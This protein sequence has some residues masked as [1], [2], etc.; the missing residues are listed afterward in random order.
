MSLLLLC[1]CTFILVAEV[2]TTS[3][4]GRISI[5][6]VS[7]GFLILIDLSF[8]VC[9]S[10]PC[11]FLA[12]SLSCP[13]SWAIQKDY[14]FVGG[15]CLFFLSHPSHLPILMHLPPEDNGRGKR[16]FL[17]TNMIARYFQVKKHERAVT[18][19][20]WWEAHAQSDRPS[21]IIM[22]KLSH[23]HYSQYFT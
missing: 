2:S 10:L 16:I 14:L 15:G 13:G 21:N 7:T 6:L 4:V 1:S 22:G 11:L 20:W 23:R 5:V 12:P 3:S 17:R 19:S 8:L 9:S 18:G